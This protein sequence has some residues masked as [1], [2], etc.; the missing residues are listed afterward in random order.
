MRRPNGLRYFRQRKKQ[1]K[2]KQDSR[3]SELIYSLCPI[4][5]LIVF[6]FEL[7]SR[8]TLLYI[9]WTLSTHIQTLIYYSIVK[10]YWSTTRIV[11]KN[12]LTLVLSWTVDVWAQLYQCWM[13]STL[14]LATLRTTVHYE[15]GRSQFFNIV[16]ILHCKLQIEINKWG[17]DIHD[18]DSENQN[19]S[20]IRCMHTYYKI[21][22]KEKIPFGKSF[23]FWIENSVH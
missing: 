9:C 7:L 22:V 5:S 11:A 15:S 12:V 2:K 10:K 20:H 1:L 4:Y 19:D 8:L 23:I 16:I 21:N 6:L 18:Q 3:F 17:V 14:T 13:Q